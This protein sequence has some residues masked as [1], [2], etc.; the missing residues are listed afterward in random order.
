MSAKK[1][2]ADLKRVYGGSA[3]IGFVFAIFLIA[4]DLVTVEEAVMSIARATY[5]SLIVF[6]VAI[7]G[8]DRFFNKQLFNEHFRTQIF[9]YNLGFTITSLIYDV[10]VRPM[11]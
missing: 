11:L 4:A 10:L 8:T 9:G 3:L 5:T 1:T 6:A 2:F 7:E